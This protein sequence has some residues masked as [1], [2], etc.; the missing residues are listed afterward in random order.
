MNKLFIAMAFVAGPVVADPAACVS[1]VESKFQR[2]LETETSK[3][4]C[5]SA[6]SYELKVCTKSQR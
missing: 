2:C 6:K 1:K 3:E 5:E 4:L